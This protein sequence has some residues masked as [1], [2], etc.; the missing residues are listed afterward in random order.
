LS[1]A[2]LVTPE[3]PNLGDFKLVLAVTS[4]TAVIEALSA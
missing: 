2:I 1:I 4:A 3:D